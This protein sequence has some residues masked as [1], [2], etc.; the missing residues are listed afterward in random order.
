MYHGLESGNNICNFK[1]A[2]LFWLKDKIKMARPIEQQL[3]K[4]LMS[5]ELNFIPIGIVQLENIYFLVQQ[6]Y[7]E[8]C[9]D[10]FFCFEAHKSQVRQ[11][12][13]KH[14]VRQVLDRLKSNGKVCN[15]NCE[16]GY[17]EIY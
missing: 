14:V 4:E 10:N 2:L 11:L 16:R 6:R 12:E 8:L 5:C 3:Y 1:Y 9:D 13:W 15:E 17:W 7:P